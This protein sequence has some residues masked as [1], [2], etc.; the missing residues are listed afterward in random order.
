ML[1]TKRE[2]PQEVDILVLDTQG[3]ELLCLKGASRLLENA[4]FIEAEVSTN[5][6]YQGGVLLSEL[7]TWLK[8]RGF[9]RKT[10]VRRQHMNAIYKRA[11]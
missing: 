2:S 5:S 11:A 1:F 4:N 3:A 8:Q 7:D 10:I 6:V 9:H